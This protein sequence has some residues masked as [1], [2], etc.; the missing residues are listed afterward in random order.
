MHKSSCMCNFFCVKRHIDEV[1]SSIAD[2]FYWL[3]TNRWSVLF[4]SF[5]SFDVWCSSFFFYRQ[6]VLFFVYFLSVFY[7]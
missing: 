1:S 4:L 3:G 5:G 2:F 6:S 7:F